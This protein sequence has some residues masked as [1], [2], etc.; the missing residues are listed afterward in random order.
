M[1]FIY[2]FGIILENIE[3]I[4]LHRVVTIMLKNIKLKEMVNGL[5]KLGLLLTGDQAQ[6]IVMVIC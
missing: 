3:V 2:R 4:G 5:R 6:V 1:V